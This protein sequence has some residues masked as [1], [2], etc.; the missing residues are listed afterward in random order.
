MVGGLYGQ[1]DIRR[2][3]GL[4]SLYIELIQVHFSYNGYWICCC[5]MGM[6]CWFWIS[7]YSNALGLIV[8]LW[9]KNT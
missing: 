6:A 5:K 4:A 1:G 2:D 7:R 3:K 9:G 8:Y